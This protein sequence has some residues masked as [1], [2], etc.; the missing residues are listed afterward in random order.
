LAI[1]AGIQALMVDFLDL[2]QATPFH[3][4]LSLGADSVEL[5]FNLSI[6]AAGEIQFDFPELPLTKETAFVRTEHHKPGPL[7]SDFIL[8]GQASDGTSFRTDRFNLQSANWNWNH[9]EGSKITIHGNC[10]IASLIRRSQPTPLP[11]LTMHLRGF[12]NLGSLHAT[13]GLGKLVM[14]GARHDKTTDVNTITG[15]VTI[16]PETLPQDLEQWRVDATKLIEHTRRVMSLASATMLKAPVVEFR[17]N[18]T[19]NIEMRSQTAQTPANLRI[20]PEMA[21]E[22]IFEAAVSSFFNP[23][24]QANTFP[25]AVEW[26]AMDA[27]YN[28]VRLVNAMTALENLVNSNLADSDR[29][30]QEQGEFDKTTRRAIRKQI[31]EC[32]ADWPEADASDFIADL[33]EK[34]PELNRRSLIQKIYILAE[35]WSVPLA[36]ISREQ[37]S[38]AIQARNSIVHRGHYYDDGKHANDDLVELWQHVTCVRELVVRF[39]LTA[40]GYRGPYISYVGGFHNTQFPPTDS[41]ATQQQGA[42]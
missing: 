23:P 38:K 25:F 14:N 24:I 17:F 40:V 21:Q 16:Q 10:T 13:S 20:I 41:V 35:R 34:L 12:S 30:I 22:S 33:N 4:R 39:L 18:E 37:I 29:L 9:K 28:E 3:G 6:N 1:A 36:K 15:W 42:A 7:Y 2:R 27:T 19:L 5:S 11:M 8:E 31:K 32:I 26:F